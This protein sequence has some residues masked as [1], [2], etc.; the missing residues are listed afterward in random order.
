MKEY[1]YK[2]SILVPVYN[3]EKY[4]IRCINSL[5]EQDI[6]S[7]D[8]EIIVVDDGS[9]DNSL[10]IINDK[11]KTE[12][13]VHIFSKPNGGLSSARNF[14]LAKAQGKYI[15]HVD[16]DDFL[17]SNVLGKLVKIAETN[18]LDLL[19]FL[20]RFYPSDRIGNQQPFDK[21]KVY[22]GNYILLNGMKVSSVWSNI[23]SHDFLKRVGINFYDKISHQDIEYNYRLYPFAQRIMFSDT[24][25]YNYFIEGE[26]ISR[27]INVDKKLKNLEDNLI[28]ARNIKVFAD[29]SNI[30]DSVANLLKRRTNSMIVGLLLQIIK[31]KIFDLEVKKSF[32]VKAKEMKLYPIKGKCES[33]KTTIL[34]QFLSNSFVMNCLLSRKNK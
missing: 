1:K 17:E 4:V 19:F 7:D 16:S 12:N 15:M 21:S 2:L 34:S 5:L 18:S 30:S 28:V 8:Y 29:T 6:K 14:A 31:I 27:T 10:S 3:V 9:T 22:T 32:I 26:S 23:Y 11:Y 25:V 24:L 33:W 20:I 13:N